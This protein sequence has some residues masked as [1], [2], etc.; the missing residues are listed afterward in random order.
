M[1]SSNTSLGVES[2]QN[3]VWDLD[4]AKEKAKSRS[5]M[6]KKAFGSQ[7]FSNLEEIELIRSQQTVPSWKEPPMIRVT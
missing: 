1:E 2:Q 5:R 7:S 4:E 3:A 6:L